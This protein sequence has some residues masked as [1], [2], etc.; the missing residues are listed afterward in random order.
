MKLNRLV[1]DPLF[2]FAGIGLAIF[3]IIGAIAPA[4]PADQIIVSE[5]NLLLF[6]QSRSKMF[7][8]NRAANFLDDLTAEERKRLIEDFVK[9]EAMYQEALKLGLDRG[10][11]VIRQRMVQKLDYTLAALASPAQSDEPA[12]EAYYSSNAQ[13]YTEPA[14]ATFTHVFISRDDSNPEL[15]KQRAE[16]LL[17]ELQASGAGFLDAP[18]FGDQFLFQ[19]NYVERN[20]ADIASDFGVEVPQAVFAQSAPLNTWFGPSKS[21]YGYHLIFVAEKLP[22]RLIPLEDIQQQV[23]RD[24]EQARKNSAIDDI[25]DSLIKEYSVVDEFA[26][27]IP[28]EWTP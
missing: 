7:E 4:K 23:E 9:E 3:I 1:K 8:P 25:V 18:R 16:R 21:S 17:Q 22:E 24:F 27:D 6:I 15:S 26:G 14:R 20:F 11:Y 12:L 10:D 28:S 5:E 19:T 2:H 13:R